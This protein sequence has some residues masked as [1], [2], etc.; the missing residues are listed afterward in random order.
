MAGIGRAMGNIL[1]V[2][3]IIHRRL[4]LSEATRLHHA[5]KETPNILGYT[6]RELLRLSDVFVAET[7]T[8]LAGVCFSVD[9]ARNWTEIAV[10]FVLPEFEGRGVGTA[11]FEAAWTRA[12][13]RRRHVFVL[14]RNPQVVKWMRAR[15]MDVSVSGWRA[16][17][18]VH[19]YMAGYMASRHRW[20]ESFRKVKAIRACP[21]LMQGVKKQAK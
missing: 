16:P 8:G 5:L 20:T 15:G 2:T 4:T 10:L 14:S 17:L 12:Q 18:P 13:E 6:V 9:M 7:D 1:S 19:W 3:Q 11:L 21:P